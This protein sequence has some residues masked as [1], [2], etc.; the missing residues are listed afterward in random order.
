VARWYWGGTRVVGVA[1]ASGL[2]HKD[3][4]GLVPLRWVFV[5]DLTATHHDEVFSS[6]DSGLF[7]DAR[8]KRGTIG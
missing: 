4:R 5:W 3:G 1:G 6:T 7:S 8:S 2:E